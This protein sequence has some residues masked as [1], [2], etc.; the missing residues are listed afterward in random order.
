MNN[1]D[2]KE[3]L[4]K[5]IDLIQNC[6]TRMSQNSFMVKGWLITLISVVLALLPE[7][8]NVQILCIVG[9]IAVLCFWF[10]DAF[11]LKTEKLYIMKYEWIIKNRK[12]SNEYIFDLDPYNSNM[13]LPQKDK[14]G[15]NQLPK[16]PSLLTMMFTKTL[17]LLYV[18]LIILTLLV[19]FM[20][21]I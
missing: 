16:A 9:I 19:F 5:E 1:S 12:S 4:Y 18:P 21:C 13:W 17:L 7:K 3:I 20:N 2:R 15:K 11:F 14:K 10:L 6:V 8:F